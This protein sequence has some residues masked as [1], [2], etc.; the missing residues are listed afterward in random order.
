MD[1]KPRP[2]HQLY[3]KALAAMTPAEKFRK[4]AELNEAGR[5]LFRAGVRAAFPDKSED[6]I[7]RIYRERLALCHNRNY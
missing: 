6:E 1:I 5:T 3:L 7:E 4:I 2:N